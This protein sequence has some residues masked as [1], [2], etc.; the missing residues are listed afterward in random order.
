MGSF[1]KQILLVALGAALLFLPFLGR[2]HL[3]DWDEINFAEIS[4][5]MIATGDY[6]RVQ[7]NYLPFWEKP[8]LFCWLQVASM[9]VFGVNEFAARLPDAI[10]GI[11][12]MVLVFMAGSRYFS[13]RLGL[14]WAL[15]YVG[16]LTPHL[17]FKSGIIDPVFNLFILL[18]LF[19]LFRSSLL[20]AGRK[21][22]IHFLWA[23]FLIGLA[24]L[25]KGPVALLVTGLCGFAFWAVN[26]FKPY[27]NARDLLFFLLAF[28]S[29]SS[30]WL[31]LEVYNN[32]T[33]NLSQFFIYQYELLTQGVAGHGQPFY[34]HPVVLLLGCF[35]ASII[36]LKSFRVNGKEEELQQKVF[37]TWMLVLFWVVL[38]LFSVVKTKIVHYSSLCYPS[39]TFLAAYVI[40]R[41]ITGSLKFNKGL[42]AALVFTG[43]LI[44]TAL[45]LAGLFP[46]LKD[47]LLPYIK[48]PNAVASI[49]LPVKWG[50][51]EWIPGACYL[52]L[53]ISSSTMIWLHKYRKG[54]ITLLAGSAICIQLF[55]LMV[56]P[57]IEEYSQGPAIRFYQGLQQQDCY[58]ETIGF[59]S[60]AYLFYAGVRPG[61]RPESK[62]MQW[63][64]TG[65]IDKPAYFVSLGH[66]AAEVAAIPGI[67]EIG[68]EGSFVFFKREAVNDNN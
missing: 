23:G 65:P 9:K 12:M 55:L 32:G 57:K 26:R 6:S 20:A 19:H 46:F 51:Y 52:L 64:K 15:A 16:S 28:L 3:F 43:L 17:Y 2:V 37:R 41:V 5:E 68:R 7:V 49:N 47:S 58:V 30:V 63:L 67:R 18:G 60:Y 59:K 4:R 22:S 62:D 66:K 34:Y 38:I 45:T 53:I 1:R 14:L 29:V 33:A 21:R 61:N 48:D 25:T 10:C 50:G 36:A 40:E 35:P 44:A 27:F 8:P 39:I 54:F 11:V 42:V 56:V 13:S 24:L 31:L